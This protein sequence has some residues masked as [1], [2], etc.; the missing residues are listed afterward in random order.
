MIR[1]LRADS[2]SEADNSSSVMLIEEC[3]MRVL[4]RYRKKAEEEDNRTVGL[5]RSSVRDVCRRTGASGTEDTH[6]VFK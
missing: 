4:V 2:V 1:V 3:V 6:Q 5:M